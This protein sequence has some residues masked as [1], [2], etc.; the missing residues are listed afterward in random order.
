MN[1]PFH[2]S[3]RFKARLSAK[4]LLWK[5]VFIHIEI[6]TIF[7]IT[8]V[9]HLDSLWRR[10]WGELGNGPLL[11]FFIEQW[12]FDKMRFTVLH[13][14]HHKVSQSV[15]LFMHCKT[16]TILLRIRVRGHLVMSITRNHES[17]YMSQYWTTLQKIEEQIYTIDWRVYDSCERKRYFVFSIGK[18]VKWK[19]SP[20]WRTTFTG[21]RCSLLP[22]FL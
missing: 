17:H 2:L 4:S 11:W 13:N 22:L 20:F 16:V 21:R 1:R 5:S 3:L 6:E 9:P 15:S 14:R 19:M 8:K 18:V 10:D 7:I 12:Y